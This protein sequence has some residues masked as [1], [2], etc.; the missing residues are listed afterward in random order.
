MVDRGK[1]VLWVV[2]RLVLAQ[3]AVIS[4]RGRHSVA[5]ILPS[6]PWIIRVITCP[7]RGACVLFF[8]GVKKSAH[9]YMGKGLDIAFIPAD[10]YVI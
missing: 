6:R 5:N 7:E 2:V 3:T 10:P 8:C 1:Q 4:L 9:Q